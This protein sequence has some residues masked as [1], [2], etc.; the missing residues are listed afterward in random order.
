MSHHATTATPPRQSNMLQN[1]PPEAKA[2]LNRM[3]HARFCIPYI[4]EQM[5]ARFNVAVPQEPPS[6]RAYALANGL[7]PSKRREYIGYLSATMLDPDREY[8]AR[9][10]AL[11][12]ARAT[13]SA[14]TREMQAMG[15]P[16]GDSRAPIKTAIKNL[17][18][19]YTPHGLGGYHGRHPHPRKPCETCGGVT[20][21]RG[22]RFCSRQC[23][24]DQP[25]KSDKRLRKLEEK[26]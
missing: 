13:Y 16:V 14:L 1:L 3:L 8:R 17:G 2:V 12:R 23:Y 15:V 22:R 9:L 10:V 24:L 18:I 20:A 6:Y 26:R 25:Q 19:P 11:V 5:A 21:R 7:Q 4:A